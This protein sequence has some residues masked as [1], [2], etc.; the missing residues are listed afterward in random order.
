[1]EKNK[2]A[3]QVFPLVLDGQSSFSFVFGSFVNVLMGNFELTF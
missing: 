3:E 1:M 2:F